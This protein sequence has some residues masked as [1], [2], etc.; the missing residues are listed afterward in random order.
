MALVHEAV[1]VTGRAGH[2][3]TRPVLPHSASHLVP[4]VAVLEFLIVSG[5]LNKCVFILH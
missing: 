4:A 3:G 5:F 2:V 1:K